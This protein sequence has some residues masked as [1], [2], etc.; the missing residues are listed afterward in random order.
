MAS[1]MRRFVI[2]GLSVI[3]LV[4]AANAQQ[5][6]GGQKRHHQKTDTTQPRPKVDEKAYSDALKS[7]PNKPYDP[8]VG[9]R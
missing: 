7:I 9:T 8:W 1:A 5:A 6:G 3:F 2:G 4:T